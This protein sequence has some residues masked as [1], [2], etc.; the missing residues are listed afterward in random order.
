MI[1]R[2]IHGNTAIVKHGHTGLLYSSPN[3][4]IRE[5]E[6]LVRDSERRDRLTKAAKEQITCCHSL[7]QE[8]EL[9][10]RVLKE[11]VL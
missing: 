2:D 7:Q 5:L 3:D 9:L 10:L 8:K 4:F 6:C 11:V 1:A